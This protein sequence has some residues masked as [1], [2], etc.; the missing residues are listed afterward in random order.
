MILDASGRPAQTPTRAPERGAARAALAEA[1]R[2]AESEAGSESV[3][4]G[5]ARD[6]RLAAMVSGLFSGLL[7]GPDGAGILDGVLSDSEVAD[8]LR[9]VAATVRALADQLGPPDGA[10]GSP[11]RRRASVLDLVASLVDRAAGRPQR[12]APTG[13]RALRAASVLWTTL[14]RG[15]LGAVVGRPGAP[16]QIVAELVWLSTEAQLL[17]AAQ[18]D[19]PAVGS[20]PRAAPALVVG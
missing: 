13:A 20:G 5:M 11:E 2:V 6:L 8:S 16:P 9:V 3:A 10:Q 7:T 19:E 15:L 12:P 1:E 18:L 4:L 17:A 14:A